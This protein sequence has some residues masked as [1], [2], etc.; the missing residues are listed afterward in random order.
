MATLKYKPKILKMKCPDGTVSRFDLDDDQENGWPEAESIVMWWLSSVGDKGIS[1]GELSSRAEIPEL[2]A[3]QRLHN[4]VDNE[5]ASKKSIG[6]VT[7]FYLSDEGPSF[8]PDDDPDD[9]EEKPIDLGDSAN[10]E[11]FY[12]LDTRKV[13]NNMLKELIKMAGEFDRLG[14]TKEADFVDDMISKLASRYSGK[15]MLTADQAKIL[16]P[17][18]PARHKDTLVNYQD[19]ESDPSMVKIY[20]SHSTDEDNPQWMGDMRRG[21]LGMLNDRPNLDDRGRGG[22]QE[23]KPRPEP[24]GPRGGYKPGDKGYEF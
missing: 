2:F 3:Y 24:Y 6:G 12:P 4:L 20:S 10:N 18:H 19:H 13:A 7:L 22:W 16:Y 8:D 17:N 23:Y 1:S 15:H 14:L 21:D 11:E 9:G 5:I